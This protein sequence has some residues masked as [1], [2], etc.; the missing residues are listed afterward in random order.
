M[1]KNWQV[2]NNLR[3]QDKNRIWRQVVARRAS[4]LPPGI[5]VTPVIDW[6]H[7]SFASQRVALSHEGV[8]FENQRIYNP[9]LLELLHMTL[10]GS[11]SS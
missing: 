10:F 6:Y 4:T 7:A 5:Q 11:S 2:Q 9:W 3:I 8:H 1:R